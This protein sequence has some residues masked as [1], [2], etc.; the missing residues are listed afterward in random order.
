M[1]SLVMTCYN[2]E[3]FVSAAIESVLRQTRKDFE[4]LVWDDGST[5]RSVEIA[6]GYADRDP[7]VRVVV[8]EH[9]GHSHSMHDAYAQTTGTYM[10]TVDSDDLLAE[11]ALEETAA[12]LDADPEVGAVYTQYMVMNE[13]GKVLGKGKRTD[14][15]YSRDG[16]LLNFMTFQFRLV[17]R[18][19]YDQ[20]GGI[21]T[22]LEFAP[23]YDLCLKLSE[24]TQFKHI[25]RP[26]YYYRQHEK[27]AS[28]ANRMKQILASQE[29]IARALK[30]RGLADQFTVEVEI[31]GRYYL[32]KVE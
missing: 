10:A 18:T 30:R 29:A 22:S 8:G 3:R 27:T 28:S 31:Q 20:V 15:P 25:Q 1:I 21:D 5:D 7:R 2:R 16:L 14:I 9:R 12:A 19:V 32:K 23:D 11:T 6:R 4:L 26:L 17:R 13:A 24:I